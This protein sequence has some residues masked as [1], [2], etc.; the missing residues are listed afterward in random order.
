MKTFKFNKVEM[1]IGITRSY[2]RYVIE[3]EYKGKH[4]KTYTTD[5]EIY[6]YCDD[7][8]YKELCQDAKRAAY[9][10]IVDAYE[11]MD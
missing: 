7:D 3:A 8:D 9:H 1:T 5:A 2:G 6:D 4:V 10:A 11:E